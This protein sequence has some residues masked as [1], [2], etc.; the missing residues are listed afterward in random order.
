MK[1]HLIDNISFVNMETEEKFSVPLTARDVLRAEYRI[2]R[3]LQRKLRSVESEK[4]SRE[5]CIE[6]HKEFMAHRYVVYVLRAAAEAM[7]KEK[8]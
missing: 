8:K 5:E 2:M 3:K 1:D 7:E 4:L 6:L